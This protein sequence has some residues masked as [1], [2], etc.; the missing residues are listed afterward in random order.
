[1][2]EKINH[3]KPTTDALRGEKSRSIDEDR[4]CAHYEK[5]EG[6][7]AHADECA[8]GYRTFLPLGLSALHTRVS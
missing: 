1:M 3:Q 7:Y 8:P 6:T 5:C 4:W 2:Q